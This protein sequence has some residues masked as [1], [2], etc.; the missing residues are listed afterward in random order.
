MNK[1]KTALFT[2]GV[3]LRFLGTRPFGEDLLIG[4]SSLSVNFDSAET[5]SYCFLAEQVPSR[6][7]QQTL[8]AASSVVPMGAPLTS[9]LLNGQDD[10]ARPQLTK[11]KDLQD[12]TTS[13]LLACTSANNLQCGLALRQEHQAS[14]ARFDCLDARHFADPT[15]ICG[16][17]ADKAS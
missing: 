4:I 9:I 11:H 7:S 17:K 8:G 1:L 15:E 14:L 13:Y 16:Q 5:V 6:R 12:I 10:G 3:I 2:P